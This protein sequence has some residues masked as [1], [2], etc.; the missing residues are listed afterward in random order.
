MLPDASGGLRRRLDTSSRLVPRLDA[1]SRAALAWRAGPS[2][3]PRKARDGETLSGE[4]ACALPPLAIGGKGAECLGGLVNLHAAALGALGPG[5]GVPARCSSPARPSEDALRGYDSAD[6]GSSRRRLPP[7][8]AEHPAKVLGPRRPLDTPT[9]PDGRQR[10]AQ[11]ATGGLARGASA[12]ARARSASPPRARSLGPPQSWSEAPAPL[13]S[14]FAAPAESAARPGALTRARTAN[15]PA[16]P[17][18]PAALS[19]HSAAPELQPRL[20]HAKSQ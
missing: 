12:G 16:R 6:D 8:H 19:R 20:R 5:G 17:E 14:P 7:G 15:F 11:A 18:G 3:H 10:E 1:G 13:R 4:Y 9:T 2:E